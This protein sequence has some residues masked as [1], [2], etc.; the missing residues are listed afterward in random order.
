[1]NTVITYEEQQLMSLYNGSGTRCGLITALLE[2][3]GY[4]DAVDGD[5]LELTNSAIEKLEAM[6][7]EDF[8]ALDLTP[9]F[10]GENEDAK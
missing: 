10:D 9:D 7:D 8:V 5:L 3:R 4:L 2:M 6:T 1:M